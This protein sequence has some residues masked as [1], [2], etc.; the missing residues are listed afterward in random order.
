MEKS[1]FRIEYVKVTDSTNDLI[2]A[3][4][5]DGDR[6]G[7][8][9][10]ADRQLCGRG[11]NGHAFFSPEGTGVYFSALLRPVFP[12]RD[13]IHITTAAAVAMSRAIENVSG[14]KTEIKWVND[15]LVDGRK[16]CGILTEGEPRSDGASLNYAILGIGVNLT[17]PH[18]GF[19]EAIRQTAGS[20][21]GKKAPDGIG[22]KTV[23]LF[24]EYFSGYYEAIPERKHL[25]G[26]VKRSVAVGRDIEVIRPGIIKRA[27]CRGI[28]GD[29][30]LI[31]T[32]EDGSDDVLDSGEISIR[33]IYG[34]S[35]Y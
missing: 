13:A 22:M 4:A 32:Y 9:I 27:H 24:L 23:S 2:R 10:V 26:Y 12:I 19:P 21:F 18:G 6:E 15:I 31:V 17:E 30:R 25:D 7:L 33:G 1:D 5:V 14:K 3:R 35:G 11:R 20:V 8:V 16:V 28:D 29:C 34:Q